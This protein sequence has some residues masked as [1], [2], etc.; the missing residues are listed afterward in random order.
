ME[1]LTQYQQN[2]GPGVQVANWKH[3]D[4][5]FIYVIL[6]LIILNSYA[7]HRNS[8]GDNF[9]YIQELEAVRSWFDP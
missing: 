6:S 1:N 4:M 8:H 3:F 2:A 9:R 7:E 5:L